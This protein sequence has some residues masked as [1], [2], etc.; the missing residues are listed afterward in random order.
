M[1]LWRITL[2]AGL[3]AGSGCAT[4]SHVPSRD[5]GLAEKWREELRRDAPLVQ[6]QDP[7][8]GPPGRYQFLFV[9]GFLHELIPDYLADNA[10][11]T[12]GELEAETSTL[13]PSSL[14][15]LLEDVELVR[16]EVLSRYSRSRKPIVLVGHSKGGAA[17]LLAVLR[18]PSWSSTGRSSASS[19]FKARWGALRSPRRWPR[20]CR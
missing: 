20:R 16:G 19:S 11:V 6:G 2:A 9:G 7:A 14:S 10:Q 4:V 5:S 3:L 18:S 17:A 1:P 12:E 13:F 15:T 8:L